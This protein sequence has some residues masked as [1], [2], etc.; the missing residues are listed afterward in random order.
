MTSNAG[1]RDVGKS[2][3]GFGDRAVTES[4]IKSAVDKTFLLSSETG[5][6]LM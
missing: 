2:M 1:A 6:M 5:L 4:A 3:I